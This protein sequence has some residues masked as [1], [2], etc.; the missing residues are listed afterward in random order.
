MDYLESDSL[1]NIILLQDGSPCNNLDIQVINAPVIDIGIPLI[2]NISLNGNLLKSCV[3]EDRAVV[4]IFNF[5]PLTN[6]VSAYEVD[7]G[8]GNFE[9]FT[10]EE[11]SPISTIE[12]A[13]E[14]AESRR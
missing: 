11:F 7:W 3:A 6:P 2:S 1:V 5:A 8:D 10:P 9:T 12:H 13:F 4:K 14:D